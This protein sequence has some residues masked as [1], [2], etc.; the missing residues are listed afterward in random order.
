M[1]EPVSGSVIWLPVPG[2]DGMYEVSNRG[3]V[4]SW[5]LRGSKTGSRANIARI[6]RPCKTGPNRDYLAVNIFGRNT[7]IHR[8]VLEVFSGSSPRQNFHARHLDGNSLNNH[9]SNL[10]WGSPAQ[11][12]D[13][14]F[15]VGT[16][17][18]QRHPTAKISREDAQSIRHLYERGGLSQKE[19]GARFGIKQPQVSNIV[20]GRRWAEESKH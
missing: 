4:R 6:L 5:C 7:K 9:A 18:S 13:D 11:N 20:C 17:P 1:G 2:T 16:H 8:L 12:S 19:I 15:I 3:Q 14:K 10:A